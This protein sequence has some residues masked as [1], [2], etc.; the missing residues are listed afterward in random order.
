M[1]LLATWARKLAAWWGGLGEAAQGWPWL[2]DVADALGQVLPLSALLAYAGLGVLS[3]A[4][5][6]RGI[7]RR[8]ASYGKGARQI[9]HLALLLGWGL[10]IGGRVWLW[11][12][13]GGA[14]GFA[15][16]EMAWLTLGGAVL[17][18]SLDFALWSAHA[19][20]PA[21][22]VA[23]GVVSGLLGLVACA[24][25]LALARFAASAPLGSAMPPLGALFHPAA[26]PGYAL[27]LAML[28]FLIL[29]L[30]GAMGGCWLVLR[31]RH[32]DF[33]RDHYNIMLPWC[34]SWARNAW[35]AF[36]P[37]LA[38]AA[39]W[40]LWGAHGGAGLPPAAAVREGVLLALWLSPLAFWWLAARSPAPL[41]H[42]PGLLAALLLA[43]AATLPWNAHFAPPPPT[44]GKAAMLPAAPLGA[45]AAMTAARPCARP[46][47]CGPTAR[48][49]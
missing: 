37:L 46:P 16:P 45:A 18:S 34:V 33:G 19:R 8:R 20:W 24:A 43:M 9:A 21:L 39:G 47:A 35:L 14:T 13:Q 15:L 12:R 3:A 49:G 25:V 7:A 40:R 28:P 42:K 30:A 27:A 29:S 44:A 48:R 4:A 22:H 2:G 11:L 26:S 6:A 10:L 32:D 1:E 41:R 23:S 17:A 38:A 36:W 5:R 31:R